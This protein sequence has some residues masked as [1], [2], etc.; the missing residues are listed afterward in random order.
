MKGILRSVLVLF[1]IGVVLFVL[2]Q[3]V[4]YG[5]NHANPPVVKEPPWKNPE[6]HTIARRACF[7]C[8]S[9]ET[10]WPWYSNVAP[11]SWLVQRDVDEGRMYMNFSNWQGVDLDELTRLVNSGAM[12]PPQ[13]M[14]LHPEAKLTDQE[15]N[16]LIEEV[17][18]FTNQ[19]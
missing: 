7:D 3:F 1:V 12:P 14:P 18:S 19:P 17:R 9:H 10:V 6:A 11:A 13:Y 15:K 4:P 8:H 5:R 16:I 2:I